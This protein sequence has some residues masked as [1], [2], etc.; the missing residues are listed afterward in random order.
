MPD[1]VSVAALAKAPLARV[2]SNPHLDDSPIVNSRT[3]GTTVTV[4][5]PSEGE[6]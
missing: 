4:D 3:V 1:G 2:L 6:P 5:I